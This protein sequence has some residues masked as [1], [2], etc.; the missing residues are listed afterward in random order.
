VAD[1]ALVFMPQSGEIRV[2]F[3]IFA[4]REATPAEIEELARDLKHKLSEFSIIAE[5]HFEFGRDV[6]A[7]VHLVRI[8]IPDAD[9]ELRGRLLETVERWAEA[10]VA[11][12]HAEVAE[13]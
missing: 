13:L 7:V 12:R 1:P 5:Q 9:D 10:C 2:N 8:E 4:G 6:E 3:G 11:E